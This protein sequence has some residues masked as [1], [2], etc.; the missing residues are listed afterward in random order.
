MPGDTPA[1]RKSLVEAVKLEEQSIRSSAPTG[2]NG[3]A[4][5]STL[6]LTTLLQEQVLKATAFNHDGVPIL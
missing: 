6:A 1:L 2:A 3:D 5:G 4:I